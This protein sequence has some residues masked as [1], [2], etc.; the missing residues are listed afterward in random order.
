MKNSL[1]SLS[2]VDIKANYGKSFAANEAYYQYGGANDRSYNVP[3]KKIGPVKT[4]NNSMPRK[5]YNNGIL[6]GKEGD[7]RQ[8]LGQTIHNPPWAI[9]SDYEYK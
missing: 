6:V 4:A 9:E 7:K 5:S 1:D 2:P 3:T 8:E